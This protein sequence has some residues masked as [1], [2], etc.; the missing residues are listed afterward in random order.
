MPRILLHTCC[1]PCLLHPLDRLREEGWTVHAYFYNPHIQPYQEL[2]RRLKALEEAAEAKDVPVIVRKDYE[3]ETFLRQTAFREG[4]RCLYCYSRRIESAARLAKKS[5]FDAFTTT[6][7][8]SKFQKH[9]LIRS[10]GQEAS[11]R[12]GVPFHY[13]DFRTGWRDGKEQTARLGIYRQHYCGC[14]YSERER[15]APR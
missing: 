8:Y 10:L 4:S 13:E 1:G 9:D 15:F 6:L 12:W 11:K 14:I 3:L 7:L 2:E 5:R